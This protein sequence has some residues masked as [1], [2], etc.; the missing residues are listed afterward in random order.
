VVVLEVLALLVLGFF[1]FLVGIPIG[2]AF[3]LSTATIYIASLVG[4]VGGTVALVYFGDR[5][6][7]PLR[8]AWKALLR[9]LLPGRDE[10]AED[11]DERPPGRR[12]ALMRALT[13]RHGALGLGLAGPWII[14]GPPTALL[15]VA[16]NMRRREHALGLA[17]TLSVMVTGYTLIVH[18]AL[19]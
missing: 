7:D 2:Y 16:L 17:I 10:A 6:M 1:N 8:L 9:R 11:V 19:R 14:G 12:A 18:S 5:V 13:E 3:G 15:G 4:C